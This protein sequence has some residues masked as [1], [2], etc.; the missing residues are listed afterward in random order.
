[1]SR[2]DDQLRDAFRREQPPADFASRVLARVAALPAPRPSWWRRLAALVEPPKLRWVA[3]GAT[4]AL[5]LA[6]GAA[7]FARL[8][9]EA[10]KDNGQVAV[11]NDAGAGSTAPSTDGSNRGQVAP[12]SIPQPS[13]GSKRNAASTKRGSP[14]AHNRAALAPHLRELKPEEEAAKE[15]LMLALHIA[16]TALNEAQKAVHDD[17]EKP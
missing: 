9:Q 3:I 12:I 2:L 17:G 14:A 7:Q 15:K 13:S 11:N 6:I 16:S 1:M 10:V 4:A 5:L 8:R